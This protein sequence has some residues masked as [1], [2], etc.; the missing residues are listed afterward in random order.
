[1]PINFPT[2]G[3]G[4]VGIGSTYGFGE[5]LWTWNGEGWALTPQELPQGPKGDTGNQGSQ[6]IQGTQGIQGSQGIQGLS[7]QGVQGTQ[8]LQGT[9]G[10]QGSQ[11]LQGL[12]GL[13]NQGVQGTQG[14]I[15]SPTGGVVGGEPERIFYL[16]ETSIDASYTVPS[17]YNALSVGP[18]TIS[19]GVSITVPAGSTWIV[20][21]PT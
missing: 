6:G 5:R 12:Q 14:A 20:I 15:F 10:I 7:N 2:V 17:G 18:H 3:V 8:G 9:Q 21:E 13:S 19:G 11:G 4:G 16:S 1:M